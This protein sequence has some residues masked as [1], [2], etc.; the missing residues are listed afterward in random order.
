MNSTTMPR[1]ERRASA[2]L[3]ARRVFPTLAYAMVVAVAS[4]QPSSALLG[5]EFVRG[6]ANGDGEVTWAD[7][8]KMLGFLFADL[9]E[10]FCADA[11][12]VNDDEQFNISDPVHLLRFLTFGDRSA[13]SAPYP[14]PGEDP[15]GEP[16]TWLP[17]DS[18]IDGSALEDAAASL[19]ILDTVA[20]G[21]AV[22]NAKIVLAVSSSTSIAGYYGRI[23]ADSILGDAEMSEEHINSHVFDLSNTFLHGY[24]GTKIEESKV[25]F[26]YMAS[27]SAVSLI[28]A[29]EDQLALEIEVCLR[30][31]TPAGEYP[32]NLSLGELVDYESGRAIYPE[33]VGGTLTVL[34]DV[35]SN[36]CI[37]EERPPFAA[38][39]FDVAFALGTG[40]AAPGEEVT[41]PFFIKTAGPTQGYTFSVDFD[42]R[43][44]EVEDIEAVFRRPDGAEYESAKWAWS[45]HNDFPGDDGVDEGFL[46]GR[47][48]ISLPYDQD[49][50]I[51]EGEFETALNFRFRVKP[52]ATAQITEL[53]FINGGR[54][55]R[56]N[57]PPA[58]WHCP[59]E[60]TVNSRG[61]AIPPEL[62]DSFVFIDGFLEIIGEVTTFRRG[63]TNS[64]GDV[65]VADAIHILE[66]L[67]A[68]ARAPECMKEA[69]VSD[70]GRV[71]ISSGLYLLNY[72]F[73]DGAPPKAPFEECGEDPTPGGSLS[74]RRSPTCVTAEE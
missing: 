35:A 39:E 6:D 43:L 61:Y 42:E 47:V 23:D 72:L 54:F 60:N 52:D 12:D 65:N 29:G 73:S 37:I 64:D 9:S 32:L 53:R 34:N 68:D 27:I 8:H 40:D 19:R 66:Y 45:N 25:T 71:T 49:N 13:P 11:G 1:T 22:R 21:G 55:C 67:F 51:P 70:V 7:G 50:V 63:D 74:C 69:D 30:E 26:G 48:T 33:L 14:D 41:I 62:F 18:E 58:E 56:R 38:P 57:T 2:V 31:G 20:A 28:P 36:E 16:S 46:A 3:T 24:I 17:C 4:V 59:T 5:G 44:L 15:T 10:V